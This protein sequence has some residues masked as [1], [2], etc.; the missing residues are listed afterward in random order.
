MTKF[1]TCSAHTVLNFKSI[2]PEH[3]PW[4]S[5]IDDEIA[6]YPLPLLEIRKCEQI[7]V[8]DQ[9]SLWSVFFNLLNSE[10]D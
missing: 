9:S 5:V 8:I 10:A 4:I 2:S 3:L 6:H 7:E 1:A